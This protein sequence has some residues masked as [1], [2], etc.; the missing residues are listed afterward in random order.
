MRIMNINMTNMEEPPGGGGGGGEEPLAMMLQQP[1]KGMKVSMSKAGRWPSKRRC[2]KFKQGDHLVMSCARKN[3]WMFH[4]HG[5]IPCPCRCPVNRSVPRNSKRLNN[6]HGCP[7]LPVCSSGR[8]L[9]GNALRIGASLPAFVRV[10]HRAVLRLSWLHGPNSNP[11]PG[12]LLTCEMGPFH[13]RPYARS[14]M[15]FLHSSGP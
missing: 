8:T 6:S 7:L 1:R 5:V 10:S 2:E 15:S 11:R 3:R 9:S 4:Q 12:W 14:M 13:R